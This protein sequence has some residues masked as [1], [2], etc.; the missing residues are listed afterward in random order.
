MRRFQTCFKWYFLALA[1][2]IIPP[3]EVYSQHYRMYVGD[4]EFIGSPDISNGFISSASFGSDNAYVEITSQN[5]AGA[6]VKITHYFEGT[7]TIECFY[8]YMVKNP[9][10]NNYTAGNSTTYYSIECIPNKATLSEN[11]IKMTIG[12]KHRLSY[13][14]SQ[15][16]SKNGIWTSNDNTIASIDNSGNITAKKSGKTTVVLDP[17]VGPLEYC[18]VSVAYI[19]PTGISFE[20]EEIS[21]VEGKSKTLSYELKPKGASSDVEWTSSDENVVKVS[22]TGKITGVSEGSAT[23]TITTENG[24]SASCKVKVIS[25]PKSVSLPEEK[26]VIQGYT[27]QLIPELTPIESET[28]YK[29]KSDD[30]SIATVSSDGMVMGK[31][32]GTTTI[33]VTTDNGLTTSC[34]VVVTNAPKGAETPNVK[35]R[36]NIIGDLIDETLEFIKNKQ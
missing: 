25:A 26:N 22:S 31:N 18:D 9:F 11:I 35:T 29:W 3:V 12:E 33:T 14:L 23:I 20:E 19:S 1:F 32:V 4:T 6:V 21:V 24:H 5:D 13:T 34:C 17:I 7:A 2:L 8:S 36:M 15:G 16:G 27:V 10:N 28:T 30:A